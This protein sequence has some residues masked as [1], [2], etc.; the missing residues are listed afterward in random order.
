MYKTK[1]IGIQ[2]SYCLWFPILVKDQGYRQKRIDRPTLPHTI[3]EVNFELYPDLLVTKRGKKFYRGRTES[4]SEVLMSDTGTE[5]GS[6]MT[7]VK[8]DCT[9]GITSEPFYQT[10]YMLGEVGDNNFHVAT[11]FMP[12]KLEETYIDVFAKIKS[13]CEENGRS[14]D[15]V[16][17]H[18]DC[19]QALMNAIKAEFPNAQI[20]LCR[21]HVVDA[22]RR[23]VNTGGLRPLVN[24]ND[25]FKQFYYRERETFYFPPSLWPRI[26]NLLIK[27]LGTEILN[28]PLVKQHL[29]YMVRNDNEWKE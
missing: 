2:I 28:L 16:Y 23:N 15:M 26:W 10:L 25:N 29:D 7:A 12:N 20:R 3:D 24:R 1:T 8:I 21:F 18:C 11:A 13:V 6:Q 4:G 14:M 5:I 19:E 27:Q 9:F 17:V 22:I